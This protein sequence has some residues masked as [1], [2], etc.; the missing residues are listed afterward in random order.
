LGIRNILQQSAQVFAINAAGD[1][2]ESGRTTDSKPGPMTSK[3]FIEVIRLV[4]IG[5]HVACPDVKKM[6]G[7]PRGEG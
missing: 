3:P 6:I 4:G 1:K 5:T 2:T 7:V